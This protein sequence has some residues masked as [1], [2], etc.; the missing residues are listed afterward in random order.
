MNV[1]VSELRAGLA[2][3]IDIASDG[4]DVIITEHGTP[5]A[6]LVAIESADTIAR[7]IEQGVITPPTSATR[8]VAVTADIPTPRGPVSQYVTEQRS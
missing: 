3:F 4:T 1:S 2:K 7:L 6:K 5:R 8:P